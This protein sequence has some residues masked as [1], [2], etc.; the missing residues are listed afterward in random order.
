LQLLESSDVYLFLVWR[1][2]GLNIVKDVYS[3]DYEHK[4]ASFDSSKIIL[5]QQFTV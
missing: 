4:T 5:Q 1:C 3:S 2:L